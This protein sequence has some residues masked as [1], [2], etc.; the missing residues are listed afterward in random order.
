M[1]ELMAEILF[2]IQAVDFSPQNPY[3]LTSGIVSPVYIDCRKLISFAN[4][5]SM[6][7]DLTE[8]V[9]L[10]HIG[11]ESID[12][13]AG[14]ETAGIPFAAFLA[15]RL[16]LP[17]I[18]IRKKAKKYGQKSQIEGHMFKGARV[19]IIED[20]VTLGGSM[21]DFIKV[22]RDSGGI[23]DN[24]IGLFF[25]NIFPE[26]FG[27]FRENNINF[28]YLSTWHDVLKIAGKLKIFNQDVLKEVQFFLENPME[29]SQKNGGIG[30]M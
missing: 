2:E 4:A 20:L 14:G 30:K 13:I 7:M 17:M 24:G 15:E 3:H 11:I 21:F 12:I 10:R 19:L 16:K 25:Y 6:V 22:V 26:S 28:H 8:K 23:I 29:W 9:V 1:A 5:R 27:R 18:Y